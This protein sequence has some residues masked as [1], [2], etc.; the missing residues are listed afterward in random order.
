VIYASLGVTSVTTQLGYNLLGQCLGAIC[1]VLS[2]SYA[3]RVPHRPVLV[4]GNSGKLVSV[5][6]V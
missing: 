5:V 3:D 6:I 4:A 1:A 2:S